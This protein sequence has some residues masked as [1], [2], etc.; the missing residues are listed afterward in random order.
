[1]HKFNF[2]HKHVQVCNI[3]LFLKG[4]WFIYL[5]QQNEEVHAIYCLFQTS[6]FF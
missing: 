4:V 1:M 3:G 5:F 6:D 2:K